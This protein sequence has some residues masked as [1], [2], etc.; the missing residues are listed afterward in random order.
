MSPSMN[1]LLIEDNP[2]DMDLVRLRLMEAHNGVTVQCANRLSDGLASMTSN[3]PGVVLLDLNLPDSHGSETFRRVIEHS[4]HVPVVVLSGQDDQELAIKAVHQGVQDY[5]IKDNLT[6]KQ[7]ERAIRYAVERQG[8]LRALEIT[9][10][11]ATGVQ[12][13]VPVARVA[14][15]AHASDLHSS[16]RES[17]GGWIGRPHAAGPGRPSENNF[18]ERESA[19]RDDPRPAGSH[20]RRE[21]EDAAS[22]RAASRWANSCS[23]ASP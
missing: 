12:E 9:Q 19:A 10:K 15:V 23:R 21:R 14:R 11:K 17:S 7:L 6:G 1:V 4:P 2:G 8:L 5:L 22:N 16:V 18:E 3:P 20:S 13:P